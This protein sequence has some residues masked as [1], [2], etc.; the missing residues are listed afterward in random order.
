MDDTISG[1]R[2][3][4][5]V[6]RLRPQAIGGSSANTDVSVKWMETGT[7]EPSGCQPL[8][9]VMLDREML[10][11][12]PLDTVQTMAATVEVHLKGPTPVESP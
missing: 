10:N 11:P 1:V 4:R 6:D 9:G 5:C 3:C 8:I 2:R 7:Y 12:K